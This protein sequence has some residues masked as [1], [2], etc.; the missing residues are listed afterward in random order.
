MAKESNIAW[1]DATFNPWMGC[2]KVSPG[3]QHC[4]AEQDRL[5]RGQ[6]LW[7]PT[8]P[9]QRTSEAYWRKPLSWQREAVASGRRLRV[10]CGSLCDV[11]EDRDDLLPIRADLM[12]LIERTPN[13]DWLLLT[14]R[15]ENFM[16]FF[17]RRWGPQWPSN[18]WAMTTVENQ[19]QAD[20]RLPHLLKVPAIV[21]GVSYEPALGPVDFVP[22]IR[23][24]HEHADPMY[25]PVVTGIH[26]IIVGGESGGGAR[27]FDVKWAQDAVEQ[28]RRAGA[29]PFVK[30]LGARPFWKSGSMQWL[31]VE[32]ITA[33]SLNGENGWSVKLD[34]PKGGDTAEWPEHLRV[35][36]FPR[37]R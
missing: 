35:Q 23:R 8:A 10:F 34:D 3:C 13:L 4:Y 18:V 12:H 36:E 14:K 27:P 31:C 7:G 22:Y 25:G 5:R 16:R 37:E 32:S 28:C 26:W 30:Q 11:C 19:E 9:R 29:T 6:R 15:P 1:T 2:V 33:S 20:K 17:G 21:R 24:M